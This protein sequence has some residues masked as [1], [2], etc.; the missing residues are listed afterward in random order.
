FDA[1]WSNPPIRIGKAPLHDLLIRWLDRLAP[2][3]AAYLV[4]QRHLGAE[5]LQRWLA[6]AG[7]PATRLGSRKGFRILRVVTARAG[8]EDR[9]DFDPGGGVE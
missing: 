3:A 5:S 9:A 7:H 6:G 8:G 1:I 2:E 4:V